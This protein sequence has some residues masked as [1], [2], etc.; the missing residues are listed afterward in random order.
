MAITK[1]SET[2]NELEYNENL[3]FFF[4]LQEASIRQNE[5]E[6]NLLIEELT[7]QNA[8]L[9]AQLQTSTQT[10]TQLQTKL[11][12]IKVRTFS[13]LITERIFFFCIFKRETWTRLIENFN[14]RTNIQYSIVVYRLVTF[15]MK[16]LNQS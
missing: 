15:E 16:L 3:N 13:F 2:R 5:R 8:R 9:T 7:A 1:S 10:E 6:K 11:Q 4:L 14:F 12:D